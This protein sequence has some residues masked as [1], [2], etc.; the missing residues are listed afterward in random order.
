MEDFLISCESKGT[1]R[2][3][4][5]RVFSWVGRNEKYFSWCPHQ[6]IIWAIIIHRDTELLDITWKVIFFPQPAQNWRSRK[7]LPFHYPFLNMCF[8][9]CSSVFRCFLSVLLMRWKLTSAN[10]WQN[11]IQKSSSPGHTPVFY[12]ITLSLSLLLPTAILWCLICRISSA[13]DWRVPLDRDLVSFCVCKVLSLSLEFSPSLLCHLFSNTELYYL[14][15]TKTYFK[16][17]FISLWVLK[18]Q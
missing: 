12:H 18:L 3:G 2:K 13:Q 8:Q 17:A 1:G 4:K 16:N 7:I 11:T 5:E 6:S 9:P 15:D 14:S 10:C